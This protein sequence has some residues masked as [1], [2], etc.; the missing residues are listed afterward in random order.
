MKKI[1]FISLMLSFTLMLGQEK[2][3]KWST[4]LKKTFKKAKKNNKPILVYF[5]GSDW[6]APCKKLDEDFFHSN[7]FAK[8]ADEF[9]LVMV[10]I[11]NKVDVISPKQ[12][13]ENK[14]WLAKYNKK[15]V[16]PYIVM[17]NHKGRVKDKISG[18]TFTRDTSLHFNFINQFIK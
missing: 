8:K 6:C 3:L 4:D 13:L 5:S 18:Y 16:F 12:M 17:L 15:K 10:D 14:E 1:V 2:S 11:P 7:D 9:N